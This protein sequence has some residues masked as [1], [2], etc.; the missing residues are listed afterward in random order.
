ME[1]KQH[2]AITK[3]VRFSYSCKSLFLLL[4]TSLHTSIMINDSFF[5]V[6][7]SFYIIALFQDPP[8][9]VDTNDLDF[10]SRMM[11]SYGCAE[12]RLPDPHWPP[13]NFRTGLPQSSSGQNFGPPAGY[14]IQSG[15]ERPPPHRMSP[16]ASSW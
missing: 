14:P 4:G 6:L 7:Y 2:T 13:Q 10:S 9:D 3:Y 8:C 12:T 1:K 15:G 16:P 11:T 5:N